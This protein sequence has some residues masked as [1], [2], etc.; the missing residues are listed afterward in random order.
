MLNDL[1][2]SDKSLLL[3]IIVFCITLI[4][5]V[6][7]IAIANDSAI[8]NQVKLATE[9]IKAGASWETIPSSTS[10]FICNNSGG[11]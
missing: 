7:I 8:S 6:L 5:I 4:V 11:K 9:C 2:S 3:G 1:D 10:T